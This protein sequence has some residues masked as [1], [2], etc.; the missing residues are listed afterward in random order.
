LLGARGREEKKVARFSAGLKPNAVQISQ[1]ATPSCIRARLQ[2]CRNVTPRMAALAAAG[3]GL[4]PRR[5]GR[6]FV[7]RLKSC[8]VLKSWARTPSPGPRRLVKTLVAVHP[9]PRGEGRGSFHASRVSRS[10]MNTD[11][12]R[13]PEAASALTEQYWVSTPPSCLEFLHL[14]GL[15]GRSIPALGNAQGDRESSLMDWA[16]K[17]RSKLSQSHT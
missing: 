7:A 1:M 10:D 9:P 12:K 15:K 8:P 16:L 2:S 3:Q 5:C 17:G 13:L 6:F 14:I 4:K 11:T